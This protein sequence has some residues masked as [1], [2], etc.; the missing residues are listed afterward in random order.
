MSWITRCPACGTTYKVVP[1]QVKMAQGWLRC[2]QCQHLFDS[3]GLVLAWPETA[4]ASASVFSSSSSS[5]QGG[6]DEPVGE[7]WVIDELLKKED[8]SSADPV[9]TAV[10]SF[11]E[12]LSTFK[13]LPP[14]P[15]S[16]V[17][18]PV[19][20]DAAEPPDALPAQPA[21]G[22]HRSWAA[23]WG[24]TCGAVALLGALALQWLWMER[25][26]LTAMQ[27][28]VGRAWHAVCRVLG[29]EVGLLQVREGVAIDSSSLTPSEGGFLLSWSVRNATAQPLQMPALELTLL[30]AQDKALVRR[31]FLVPQLDA[32]PSL[33]PGQVW[34]GQLHL[35]FEE[36]VPPAGYRLLSFYP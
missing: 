35:E 12:A 1:D 19:A 20:L 28:A 24:G 36:G 22:R 6:A 10:A 18:A 25:Q 2:G 30:D 5:D 13:P 27:P 11:E 31:V 8:R 21:Q 33:A 15:E 3:T 17:A 7:R 26:M 34:D 32:P 29:C 23:T 14:P 16:S 9:M 4:S